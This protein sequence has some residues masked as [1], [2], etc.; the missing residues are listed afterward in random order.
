MVSAKL[1]IESGVDWLTATAAQGWE[2]LVRSIWN[3]CLDEQKI[4]PAWRKPAGW[5]GYQGER[6]PHGFYGERPDGCCISIGGYFAWQYARAFIDIGM[7]PSRLDLQITGA[8]FIPPQ[9]AIEQMFQD[10]IAH[11]PANGRPLAVKCFTGRYGPE[12][13]YVGKRSSEVMLRIYDKGL[14]SHEQQYRGWLRVEAE[15]KQGAARRY[16]NAL[17]QSEYTN[18]F[19]ASAVAGLCKERGVIIPFDVGGEEVVLRKTKAPSTVESKMAWLAS[20]V[21][22]TVQSLLNEVEPHQLVELL[23]GD[24]LNKHTPP[25]IID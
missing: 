10:A 15:L 18:P 22:P 11:K 19:C 1:E 17:L 23:F 21:S 6:V 24:A 13:L 7:R 3:Q 14:E 9:R 8:P 4:G 16:A 20:Q 12:G 5:L 25:D 2:E